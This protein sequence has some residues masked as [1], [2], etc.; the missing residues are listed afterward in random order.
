MKT[1]RALLGLLF[2]AI[3]TAPAFAP[4]CVDAAPVPTAPRAAPRAVA[5]IVHPD[6]PVSDLKLDD[7][8]AL[9]T[10]ERQFWEDRSRVVLL[11]R[12][13][14]TPEQAVLLRDV[15]AMDE[16]ALRKYWVGKLYAGKIAAIPSVVK[17]AAAAGKL[18]QKPTGALT[19]VLADEL[20]AGVKVVKIDGKKPGDAGYALATKE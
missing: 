19:V 6:N 10:L 12:P 8:K 2:A 14:E 7:L 15:Y 3:A 18:V 16:K 5:V 17:T 11:A 1:K 9:L 20:P 4:Q 13:A